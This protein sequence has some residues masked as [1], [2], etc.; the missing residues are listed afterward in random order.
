MANELDILKPNFAGSLLMSASGYK[1]DQALFE[2]N[3]EI[4]ALF[5]AI[6][7]DVDIPFLTSKVFR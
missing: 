2:L 5:A 3:I 7:S 1:Y 6:F 4:S